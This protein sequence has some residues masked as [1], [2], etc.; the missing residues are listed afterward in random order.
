MLKVQG[1]GRGG[2]RAAALI[3]FLLL[4][5]LTLAA[6]LP[7]LGN[8]FVNY[9]D[10][11]YVT[12]NPFVRGGLTPRGLRWAV[13]A[14]HAA[15]WHPLTWVSHMLDVSVFGLR[16]AGH[17]LT[18]LALHLANALLLF[19]LLRAL[20]GFTWR[21][22]LVAGVFAAH[23]LRVESVAWVAERKDVLSTLLAL[24]AVEAYRRGRARGRPGQAAPLLLFALA[25][26]A[27]PM[28]VSL[29]ALLLLLDFWPLGRFSGPGFPGGAGPRAPRA[30]A[31]VL[32]REKIPYL[33]IAAAATALTVLA[34]GSF[35]A[36]VSRQ[37]LPL[38][39]RLANAAVSAVAYLR[40]ALRPRDLTFFHPHPGTI[41][42]ES[43]IAAVALLAALTL[44]ALAQA[45][46]RPWLAA[47]WGWYLAGLTPAA[48]IVQVG[49]Q[50]RADRYTYLPL[51]GVAVALV[52][53]AAEL[54][55]R[56]PRPAAPARVAACLALAA[57]VPLTRAQVGTWRDS[58]ALMERAL[59]VYPYGWW[60]HT[61][62][63]NVLF[64][65]GRLREVAGHYEAAIRS[66][67]EF[68]LAHVNL[69]RVLL[70]EGDVPAA[71]RSFGEALRIEPVLSTAHIGLGLAA[72]GQGN[73]EEAVRHYR[74]ALEARPEDAA[75]L[76]NLGAALLSLGRAE[77]AE[78]CFRQAL[79]LEPGLAE[80]HYNLGNLVAGRRDLAAAV[81]CY[82]R[83]L[84]ADPAYVEAHNNL[85]AALMLLGRNDEAER[86]L[87]EAL[88]LRPDHPSAGVNLARLRERRASLESR[89]A[90]PER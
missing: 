27:K 38:A 73:L 57:L 29:P 42:A 12:A 70:A 60:A 19:A 81:E 18:S 75:T 41:P 52:W 88:R 46:R 83:A 84:R 20:T 67:P 63:G 33:L 61:N 62:L 14:F 80:A 15:N 66:R 39:S 59:A 2:A 10:D 31:A 23:P 17:H 89:T 87:G 64:A 71:V 48:G 68:A 79:E 9:D 78:P 8:D 58:R 90:G 5:A 76:V 7:A 30:P 34:Q 82:R 69:G 49:E 77:E 51:V 6:F 37:R 25:L 55:R 35:G 21:S 47:G 16:P 65:E 36:V 3:P 4:G 28:V 24:L 44:L 85:G 86:E 1:L 26:A 43:A 56:Y 74:R 72:A 50:A 53:G 22:F 13:T 45:R 54:L 32:L 11:D 40:D